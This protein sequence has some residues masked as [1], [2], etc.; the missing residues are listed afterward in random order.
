MLKYQGSYDRF[1]SIVLNIGAE[2]LFLLLFL[3]SYGPYFVYVNIPIIQADAH[4]YLFM[5]FDILD[6]KIPLKGYVYSMPIFLSILLAGAFKLGITTQGFILIQCIYL[7]VSILILLHIIKSYSQVSAWLCALGLWLYVSLPPVMYFNTCLYTESLY[8]SS[9]IL[10]SAAVLGYLK[11]RSKWS[12][13]VI[14]ISV[15]LIALLRSNGGF[16]LIIP[17]ALLVRD[18]FLFK[19]LAYRWVLIPIVATLLSSGLMMLIWGYPTPFQLDRLNSKLGIELPSLK[20]VRYKEKSDVP[21]CFVK[22]HRGLGA[23]SALF[24]NYTKSE[25]GNFY[26]FKLRSVVKEYGIDGAEEWVRWWQN[27]GGCTTLKYEA[28]YY[29]VIPTK[30]ASRLIKDFSGKVGSQ[31]KN[32]VT[33]LLDIDKRPRN[34]WLISNYAFEAVIW[35]HRNT[36]VLILFYCCYIF[37]S[38]VYMKKFSRYSSSEYEAVFFLGMIHFTS[39]FIYSVLGVNARSV[40]RYAIVTE[41][42]ITVILFLLLGRILRTWLRSRR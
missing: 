34:L 25:F 38:Y 40:T 32:E 24:T 15:V 36:A 26:Y 13:A 12:F 8:T 31:K 28:P 18:W 35:L 1:N 2:L 17:V 5:T 29:N 7:V 6:G 9:L 42:I 10:L 3:F 21:Q 41:F 30:H 33:E 27:N 16:I 11:K 19:K 37:A 22:A 4:E 23:A 39:L 20:D 14:F